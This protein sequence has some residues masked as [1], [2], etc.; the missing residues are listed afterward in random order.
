MS[1]NSI[2]GFDNH[3]TTRV[4]QYRNTNVIQKAIVE[5]PRV[6]QVK[7]NVLDK[8]SLARKREVGQNHQRLEECWLS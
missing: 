7:G 8:S 1:R 5:E 2:Q 4:E 3:Y 6:I